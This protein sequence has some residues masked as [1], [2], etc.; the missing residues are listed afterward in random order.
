MLLNNRIRQDGLFQGVR[1]L[2]Y[3]KQQLLSDL[4]TRSESFAFKSISLPIKGLYASTISTLFSNEEE[5]FIKQP[6]NI[7]IFHLIPQKD[8][9]Q[10]VLGYH[11]NHFNRKMIDYINSWENLNIDKTGYRLTG[12]LSLLET[13]GMSPSLYK[14]IPT[15]RVELFYKFIESNMFTIEQEPNERMNLFKGMLLNK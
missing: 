7:F 15:S 2:E 12:I 14:K 11:K 9:T 1:D 8:F 4:K 3:Y 5:T 6:L 10:L 13:W